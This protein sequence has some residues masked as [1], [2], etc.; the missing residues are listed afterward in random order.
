MLLQVRQH[1]GSP[2]DLPISQKKC[3]KLSVTGSKVSL[4]EHQRG[5]VY[6]FL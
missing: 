1:H 6:L 3:L 2:H 5:F 4:T